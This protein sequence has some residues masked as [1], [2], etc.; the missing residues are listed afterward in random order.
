MFERIK[1]ALKEKKTIELPTEQKEDDEITKLWEAV[2]EQK[3]EIDR[4]KCK[5]AVLSKKVTC[6]KTRLGVQNEQTESC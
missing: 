1:N 6:I 5:V 3:A 4:L 2:K